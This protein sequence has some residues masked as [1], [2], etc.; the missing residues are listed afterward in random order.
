MCVFCVCLCVCF[1]CLRSCVCI[2]VFAFCCLRC[3]AITVTQFTI[4]ICELPSLP[5][6]LSMQCEAHLQLHEQVVLGGAA[7]DAQHAH[8][9]DVSVCFVVETR[10]RQGRSRMKVGAG[11]R[12]KENSGG[13]AGGRAR[14]ARQQP[15]RGAAQRSA[16]H[17]TAHGARRSRTRFEFENRGATATRTRAHRVQNLA[18]L[19][20]DRLE[21]R[22]RDVRARREALIVSFCVVSVDGCT[23]LCITTTEMPPAP[24]CGNTATKTALSGIQTKMQQQKASRRTREP[25]QRAARVLAPVRC[26]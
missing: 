19:E 3:V 9:R 13:G 17:S 15:Q 16:A 8:V 25:E 20:A 23:G 21:R 1:V 4:T 14:Q 6:P 5:H 2:R 11:K 18:R 26:Q 7:V 12:G 22:A 24:R 10:R